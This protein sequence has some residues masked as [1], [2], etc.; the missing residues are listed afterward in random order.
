MMYEKSYEDSARNA[1]Q[2]RR[3][4]RLYLEDNLVLPRWGNTAFKGRKVIE[5]ENDRQG[6]R[7]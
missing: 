7:L 4:V 6:V 2:E 3:T 5:L 1:G